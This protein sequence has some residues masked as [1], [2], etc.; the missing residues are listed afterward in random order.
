M[1]MKTT[2]Y[3]SFVRSL[4][5]STKSSSASSFARGLLLAGLGDFKGRPAALWLMNLAERVAKDRSDPVS[6]D[7]RGWLAGLLAYELARDAES[8]AS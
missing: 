8:T 6:D 3:E 5:H 7:P 4:T 2:G 1:A